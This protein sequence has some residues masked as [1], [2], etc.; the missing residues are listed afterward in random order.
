MIQRVAKKPSTNI[1]PARRVLIADDHKMM[2]AGLRSL[3]EEQ[4]SNFDC[5]GEADDGVAAVRMAKELRPD[6]VVMDIAMPNLNGLDA[7]REIKAALPETK[8]IFTA[9]NQT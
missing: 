2:R 8:V 6:I 5:V 7:T 9:A 3:L 1:S 4:K